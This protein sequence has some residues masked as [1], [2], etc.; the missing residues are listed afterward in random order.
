MMKVRTLKHYM[1]VQVK[2]NIPKQ[3][4]QLK[5]KPREELKIL[6]L[7]KPTSEEKENASII[8]NG[9]GRKEERKSVGRKEG[10]VQKTRLAELER[11]QET[12]KIEVENQEDIREIGGECLEVLVLMV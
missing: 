6:D 4:A 11:N 10:V 8:F 2:K 9:I 3:K 7:I 5:L 1:A 12:Q